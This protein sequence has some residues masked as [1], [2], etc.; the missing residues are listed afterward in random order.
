MAPP[1]DQDKLEDQDVLSKLQND[2][3]E[4]VVKEAAPITSLQDAINEYGQLKSSLDIQDKMKEYFSNFKNHDDL[5]KESIRVHGELIT[6]Y[7]ERRPGDMKR[8]IDRLFP[9]P[10]KTPGAVELVD[11]L[12]KLNAQAEELEQVL[13]QLAPDEFVLFNGYC[14]RELIFDLQISIVAVVFDLISEL[15]KQEEEKKGNAVEDTK[16]AKLGLGRI[17]SQFMKSTAK[18]QTNTLR[19]LGQQIAEKTE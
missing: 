12:N 6:I 8:N 17:L 4:H 2:V 19:S 16:N 9:S 11:Q 7:E 15:K 5:L 10:N 3:R 1:E 13:Q 14:S 18:A